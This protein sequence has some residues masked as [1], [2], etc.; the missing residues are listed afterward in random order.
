MSNKLTEHQGNSR[1]SVIVPY[2]VGLILDRH[3]QAHQDLAD[4]LTL[5]LDEYRQSG[6]LDRDVNV[7]ELK[8]DGAPDGSVLEFVAAW[9]EL[10]SRQTLM[11]LVGPFCAANGTALLESVG[12]PGLP[13]LTYSPSDT[14]VGGDI[15][16][17]PF[18]HVTDVAHHLLKFALSVG[19]SR[20]ALVRE[21]GPSGAHIEAAFQSAAWQLRIGRLDVVDHDDRLS[22]ALKDA[23]ADAVIY[24]GGNRHADID[25]A[26]RNAGLDLLKLTGIEIA[27]ARLALDA[28]TL[29]GWVGLDM[30]DETN[31]TFLRFS[32]AFSQRYGRSAD[33]AYA[34]LGYDIGRVLAMT[35]AIVRP[36]SPAGM[37]A[38]LNKLRMVPAATG[39]AGTVIS[40]AR[41][42]RRG[43][44]GD[45][46]VL[47]QVVQGKLRPLDSVAAA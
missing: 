41:Y 21:A 20:V 31:P 7:V 13:V 33:H 8:A 12:S 36:P 46:F 45:P 11:A 25:A 16:Q 26:L 5:A 37:S 3:D 40:F 43:F 42:D 15:F 44:R 6:N 2:E 17:L 4:A 27:A 32:K 39:A 14:F 34:A 29:D 23:R 10:V 28:P 24:V 47:R 1:H 18:G 19:K 38:G 35:L 30:I 9:K 22:G